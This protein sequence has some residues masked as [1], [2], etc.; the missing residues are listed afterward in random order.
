MELETWEK[1]AKPFWLR[2][3]DIKSL[4]K[5]D[6]LVLLALDRNIYDSVPE[7][8]KVYRPTKFF[9]AQ[10]VLYIHESGSRGYMFWSWDNYKERRKFQ[11]ELEYKPKHCPFLDNVLPAYDP[12]KLE[13][14]DPLLGYD[15]DWKDTPGYMHVG[16]RGPMLKWGTLA[17]LPNVYA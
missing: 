11:W 16:W 2:V 8:G 17:K 9:E 13:I 12:Q 6:K 4:K 14:K 7:D 5:G 15:L 10:K 3:K 1:F